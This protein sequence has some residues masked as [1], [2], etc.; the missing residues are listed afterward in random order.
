MPKVKAAGPFGQRA[1]GAV[2][3]ELFSLRS[4]VLNP[5]LIILRIPRHVPHK[6]DSNHFRHQEPETT[7][8]RR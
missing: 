2:Q 5:P 8:D 1:G 6:P 3:S 4:A 7:Y